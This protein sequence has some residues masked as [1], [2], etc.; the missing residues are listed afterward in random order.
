M[1]ITIKVSLTGITINGVDVVSILENIGSD[2]GKLHQLHLSIMEAVEPYK[3]EKVVIKD[4]D[5]RGMSEEEIVEI[6]KYHGVTINAA[7]TQCGNIIEV[8]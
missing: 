4:L 5:F 7:F 1:I 2:A 6:S 8:I 3:A